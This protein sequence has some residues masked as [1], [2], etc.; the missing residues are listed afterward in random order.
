MEWKYF[1]VDSCIELSPMR[2]TKKQTRLEFYYLIPLY[3]MIIVIINCHACNKHGMQVFD[4]NN[5]II[6]IY[7]LHY[8]SIVERTNERKLR[9]M[10]SWHTTMYDD[11]WMNIPYCHAPYDDI[12][13]IEFTCN[14]V[15]LRVYHLWLDIYNNNIL[16]LL[17]M[18]QNLQSAANV[19]A[20][21]WWTTMTT[22]LAYF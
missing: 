15:H 22:K 9:M 10:N 4:V 8:T 11:K 2:L 17:T 6:V 16:H 1:S 21:R 7:I 20:V 5:A 13:I 19:T 14:S 12:F 18:V 3:N